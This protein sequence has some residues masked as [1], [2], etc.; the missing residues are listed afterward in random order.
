[1]CARK[2][3]DVAG[4][5]IDNDTSAWNGKPRPEYAKLCGAVARGD[6]DVVVAYHHDRLWRDVAEQQ[7][8]LTLGRSS[9]LRLVATPNGTFDPNDAD[10]SFMSTILVAAAAKESGDKSRRV[11]SKM[12]AN[13]KA[14]TSPGGRRGFGYTKKR[15]LVKRE[16][17]AIRDAAGVILRG[18]TLR[19]I[20]EDWTGRG[21]TPAGGGRCW[22]G[23]RVSA[24]LCQ[25]RIAGLSVYRGEVVGEAAWPPILDRA[26]FDQVSAMLRSRT[27][28]RGRPV[29][30][31][32]LGGGALRCGL[33]GAPMRG[34]VWK[35]NRTRYACA[36]K[37]NGGCAKITVAAEP[38]EVAIAEQLFAYLDSPAFAAAL[39]RARTAAAESND[40]GAEVAD[41]LA[42]A[43]A[44]LAT[45]G[46]SFA[47]GEMERAEYKR[48]GERVR[49]E[50]AGLEAEAGRQ[51]GSLA[52]P[53]FPPGDAIRAGWAAMTVPERH[54]IFTALAECATVG[55]SA[56]R[57][58]FEPDRLRVTWRFR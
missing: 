37:G 17:E 15:K 56:S 11:R 45:L 1:V 33:C 7:A 20:V 44:R 34:S 25:P 31:Y 28:K 14:G 55:P 21:L 58:R 8:F 41:K 4:L 42:R 57:Q 30:A 43:R 53:S 27:R 40:R 35:G 10:D 46:E 19:E 6:L 5:Y 51:T 49:G 2:V 54:R 3:W 24:M 9:G 36:S 48:L 16:A 29:R 47:D 50:I 32:W 13:A 23:S 22:T 12:K 18:G 39:D 52:L 26:T 38:A